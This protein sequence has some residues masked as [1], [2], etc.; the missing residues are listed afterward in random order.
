M[1]VCLEFRKSQTTKWRTFL[2]FR[3]FKYVPVK[4]DVTL[5][6][7][8]SFDRLHMVEE[9]CK[10]WE[11]R[12]V[13]FASSVPLLIAIVF[14]TFKHYFVRNRSRISGMSKVHRKL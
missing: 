2:F 14:R 3:E 1:D 6:A 5:V 13:Y 4:D 7:H 10:Y 11:G 8:A 12:S 9:L